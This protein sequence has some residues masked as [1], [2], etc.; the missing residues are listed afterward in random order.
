MQI[1]S[2][3]FAASENHVIGYQNNLPWRLSG[4]LK[5]FKKIT[6]G[7]TVIMGRKT[8]ESLGK[9]LPNRR[10]I[11]VSSQLSEIESVEIVPSLDA[12]LKL[13]GDEEEVFLIGGAQIFKTAFEQ[14]LVNKI[15][16]TLVHAET[17]GDV[18]FE[19]PD[20]NRWKIVSVDANQ[21][22]EKNEYAYTFITMIAQ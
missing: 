1:I 20:K 6:T 2:V 10:N 13:C 14:K 17:E 8:F 11:I 3:I 5:Y 4:D 12:A 16:F 7:K 9:A 19:I 15:Y 22:D 18:F 21:A